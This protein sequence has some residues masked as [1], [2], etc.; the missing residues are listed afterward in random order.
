MKSK[1][2]NIR[3]GSIKKVTREDRWMIGISDAHHRRL[4]TLQKRINGGGLSLAA[5]LAYVI[6]A[7]LRGTE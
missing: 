7:G 4:L 2:K 3:E 1:A 5:V 6:D